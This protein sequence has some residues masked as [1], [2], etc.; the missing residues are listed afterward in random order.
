M[1]KFGTNVDLSDEKKWGAQVAELHKLPPF[2]RVTSSTNML[3]YMGHQILGM[4]TIQLYMKV[5][6]SRTP[7]HQENNNMAALNVNIGPGDC[8]WFAVAPEYWGV[9]HEICEKH[10]INYLTGSWWPLIEDMVKENVPIYRFLQ[11]PGDMVWINQGA[12][13]WV[14]AKG[15]CNNIAWNTGPMTNAQYIA[16]FERYEWNKLQGVKSIVPMI[17]LS[18]NLARYARV[19]DKLLVEQLKHCLEGTLKECKLIKERLGKEG[20]EVTFHGREEEEWT[21]YCEICEVEVFNILFVEDRKVHCEN[22]ARS[23]N[24]K[25]TNFV[26]L[27]EYKEKDMSQTMTDFKCMDGPAIDSELEDFTIDHARLPKCLQLHGP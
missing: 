2:C 15:W 11:Q 23:T 24:K 13:H 1:I 19:H 7:G 9:F 10:K 17:H 5:P 3:S 18:W 21:H 25:L 20:V 12:I 4:N 26:V 27:E 16:A 6:G 8:E 14:Q 22:C